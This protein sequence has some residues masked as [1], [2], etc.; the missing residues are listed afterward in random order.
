MKIKPL[1]LLWLILAFLCLGIG[2]IGVVLPILPT[3]PFLLIASVCFA[4]SSDK[5]HKWFMETKLYKR[6]LDS[7]VTNRS[8]T[9]KT[10]V[11]ILIPASIM[12]LFAF[13]VMHNIPGRVVIGLLILFKYYY[14]FFRI[15]TV[16]A[17]S[18]CVL[19]RNNG[20]TKI[21]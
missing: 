12:L 19:L 16:P 20:E 21:R 3:T 2:A 13:I 5:F 18:E 9:L 7:F 15:K 4:K 11:C 10:K 6:H 14:F 8:M 17:V 1:K